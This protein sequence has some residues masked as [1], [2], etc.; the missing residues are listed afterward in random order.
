MSE[1]LIQEKNLFKCHYIR[2]GLDI[3]TSRLQNVLQ[4]IVR[5]SCCGLEL[6]TNFGIRQNLYKK[7]ID[8]LHCVRIELCLHTYYVQGGAEGSGD[9]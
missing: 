7:N 8:T 3:R 1:N 9:F 5:Y 2:F 4:K 6:K